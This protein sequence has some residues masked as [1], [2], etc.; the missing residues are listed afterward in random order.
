MTDQEDVIQ[1]AKIDTDISD[2]NN[3]DGE[4]Y[5]NV[6]VGA[7]A[8]NNPGN[9]DTDDDDDDDDDGSMTSSLEK[10]G[11]T[12]PNFMFPRIEMPFKNSLVSK[13]INDYLVQSVSMESSTSSNIKEMLG[14]MINKGTS[15]F[16]AF[17]TEVSD[18]LTDILNVNIDQPIEEYIEEIQIEQNENLDKSTASIVKKNPDPLTE[19]NDIKKLAGYEYLTQLT[20]EQFQDQ[21]FLRRRIKEILNLDIQPILQRFLIQ[22]LMSRSFIEKQKHMKEYL[23]VTE[24]PNHKHHEMEE[25]DSEDTES[26]D[27]MED[28]EVILTSRD[29]QPTYY[30]L[31]EGILGCEHYQRNCKAECPTC[32]KWYTCRFCHDNEITSHTLERK[33]VKHILCMFCFTPQHPQQYCIACNRELSKYYCSK[34]KLFDNDPMKNIYH[35]DK[36]GICR[37]GLGLNQDYFHCNSCNACISIDLRENHVCIENSTRSNCPICDEFMFSSNEKVVFMSCGHPIHERCYNAHTMHSYKCPTCSKTIVNMELSFRMR[38]SEISQSQMP[39]ELKSW[40]VEIK[41]IDCGGMSRVPYHYMG[42]KCDHCHSYNTMQVKL[43]KGG[44]EEEASDQDVQSESLNFN[45]IDE[46]KDEQLFESKQFITDSLK[47]NFEFAEVK[48]RMN[49]NNDNDDT[50]KYKQGITEEDHSIEHDYV[51]NFVRVINNFEKY[52][53]IGDAFKDWIS[54]SLEHDSD[55]ENGDNDDNDDNDNNNNYNDD[56]HNKKKDDVKHKDS[57]N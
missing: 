55:D 33:K 57:N 1:T 27:Y 46:S 10:I 24:G 14:G 32:H 22:K 13:K 56:K 28:D 35:C 31:E 7:K 43:I 37:L 36:C 19:N 39:D 17:Y 9:D 47:Q 38:D 45:N 8:T 12:I 29:M 34:C 23:K 25:N 52:S 2:D 11:V 54:T 50:E 21:V 15:D 3:N 40:T 51:E 16:K 44:N 30:N 18:S 6:E 5:N 20:F 26:D 49:I 4:I 42:H 53:S 48:E 41:C